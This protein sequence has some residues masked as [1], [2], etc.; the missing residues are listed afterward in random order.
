MS[1]KVFHLR[2]LTDDEHN[3][4]NAKGW[5]ASPELQRRSEITLFATVGPMRDAWKSG[6][7]VLVAEVAV[8]NL[9]RAYE[10]TNH[11]DRDWTTNAGVAAHVSR[12]RSTSM[13]D[14]MQTADGKLHAV[15]RFG[16]EEL[17]P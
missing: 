12:V 7:Y 2:P 13:G 15:A 5:D 16:F 17:Q 11:I 6:D 14:V 10:L 3:L 8:T 9:E 4:V 1:I